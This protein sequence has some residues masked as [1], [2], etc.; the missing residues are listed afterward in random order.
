MRWQRLAIP[1]VVAAALA[2]CGGRS[3]TGETGAVPG[4]P[5]DSTSMSIPAPA[6]SDSAMTPAAPA[7][8][9]PAATTDTSAAAPK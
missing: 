7:V 1:C 6:A 4:T 3:D 9:S 2:A 5:T 8:S